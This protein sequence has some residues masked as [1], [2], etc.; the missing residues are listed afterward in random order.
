MTEVH[1]LHCDISLIQTPIAPSASDSHFEQDAT[2]RRAALI[3]PVGKML[4]GIT[5]S[6]S[7]TVDCRPL[8]FEVWCKE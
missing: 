4:L 7:S 8:D 3:R 1:S 2:T 5:A 6:N